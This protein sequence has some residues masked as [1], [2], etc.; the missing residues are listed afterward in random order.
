M[1]VRTPL[2]ANVSWRWKLDLLHACWCFVC[3][4]FALASISLST[5][6]I[7]LTTPN[8]AKLHT[9]F[10]L[11]CIESGNIGAVI[12]VDRLLG[13]LTAYLRGDFGEDV[14]DHS[15]AEYIRLFK[16][17]AN[18]A[19]RPFILKAGQLAVE[20]VQQ[21]TGLLDIVSLVS[22]CLGF[23]SLG[24]NIGIICC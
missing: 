9:Q 6:V 22:R 12:W 2:S 23:T 5:T 4:P 14:D 19:K 8:L 13:R 7:P 16:T 20:T 10:A 15:T 18:N 3:P 17:M 11:S 24:E 1:L 21:V